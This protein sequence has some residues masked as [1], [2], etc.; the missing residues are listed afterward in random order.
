MMRPDWIKPY[1]D[2]VTEGWINHVY[3]RTQ[4]EE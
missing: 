3:P 4:R 1:D 2:K